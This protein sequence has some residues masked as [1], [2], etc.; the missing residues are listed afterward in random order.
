VSERGVVEAGPARAAPRDPAEGLRA[1]AVA[2]LVEVFAALSQ[3]THN[4]NNPMTGLLGRAQ[5][6]QLRADVQPELRKA[7]AVI[8][9][10]ARRVSE[11][12]RELGQTVHS[13]RR[14]PLARL[15]PPGAAQD[16]EDPR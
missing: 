16:A 5:L 10:S 8:E 4:I 2:E 3:L 14:G 11:L 6:L 9:E 1:E 12:V 7:V 13:A 15:Q